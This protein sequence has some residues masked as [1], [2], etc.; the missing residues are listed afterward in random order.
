VK[1][2]LIGDVHSHFSA[3]SRL[4]DEHPYIDFAIQVG[5]LGF[6]FTEEAAMKDAKAYKHNPKLISSFIRKHKNNALKPLSKVV[7]FVKGNHDDYD[8]L[9]SNEMKALNLRFVKQGEII[10]VSDVTI[11]GF[12][13][14]YSPIRSKLNADNLCERQK[15]FFTEDEALMAKL[16]GRSERIDILILHNAPVGTLPRTSREE[17]LLTLN[18]IIEEITPKLIVHGHHHIN[19]QSGRVIGLGNFSKNKE[20]YVIVEKSN[21]GNLCV[22]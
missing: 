8:M 20:S 14:I 18:G 11:M 6:F 4:L 3:L 2:L 10:R 21:E 1:I 15:R 17:G 16:K 22:L 12:G 5:D 13:G 7:Y 9:D 19:Y